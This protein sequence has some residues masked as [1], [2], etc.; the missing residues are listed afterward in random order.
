MNN[1]QLDELMSAALDGELDAAD[2]AALQQQLAASD[3]ARSRYDEMRD[4]V[5][6]IEQAPG[7]EPPAELHGR[8]LA[9]IQLPARKRPWFGFFDVWTNFGRAVPQAAQ[10]LVAFALG[11]L[12]VFG[13]YRFAGD[14]TEGISADQLVGTMSR[15][16]S[17]ETT[18][19]IGQA[20]GSLMIK[21]TEVE[22]QALF[23]KVDGAWVASFELESAGPILVSV[24]LGDSDLAFMGF[25]RSDAH[26][27][28]LQQDEQAVRVTTEGSGRFAIAVA[29]SS[30]GRPATL[31]F[32]ISS[33][34]RQVFAGTL[35]AAQ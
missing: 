25:A 9:G 12:V 32:E 3:D 30:S 13:S 6:F 16:M 20:A 35:D 31:E 1:Q 7:V 23:K 8:I 22:G 14:L 27:R 24:Q 15:N 10:L 5:A 34:G 17:V 26:T 11:A 21:T 19:R 28:F 18:S 4:L 29:T 2:Q 33:A